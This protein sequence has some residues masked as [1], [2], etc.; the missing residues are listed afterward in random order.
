VGS[1]AITL[2]QIYRRVQQWKNFENRLR[3]GK[4][5]D[6]SSLPRFYVP[7]CITRPVAVLKHCPFVYYAVSLWGRWYNMQ[8]LKERFKRN[9][10][11]CITFHTG[12]FRVQHN[13][14][15]YLRSFL[16]STTRWLMVSLSRWLHPP[17]RLCL[18][19]CLSVC[20]C[21]CLLATLRENFQTDLYKIFRKGW[22]GANE[23]MVK[24][25]WWSGSPSGYRD[26]FPDSSLLGETESG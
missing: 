12:T 21:V 13:F 10:K 25:W 2:L 6:I 11:E 17:R 1:L 5:I 9:W 3:F 4:V 7:Q 23:Q 18:R 8:Q 14:K 15:Q 20:L 16:L 24:F 19:R 26:C 22:Q